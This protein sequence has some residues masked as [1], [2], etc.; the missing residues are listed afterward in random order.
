MSK[1]SGE[2]HTLR[3]AMDNCDYWLYKVV[4]QD[5]NLLL[6]RTR[7]LYVNFLY[8]VKCIYTISVDAVYYNKVFFLQIHLWRLNY[9]TKDEFQDDI[10]MFNTQN[11]RDNIIMSLQQII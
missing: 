1:L 4:S 6:W 3:S 7:L 11:K 8:L 9:V 2:A 5:S 10:I